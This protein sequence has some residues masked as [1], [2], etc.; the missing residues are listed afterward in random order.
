MNALRIFLQLLRRFEFSVTRPE[1][2]AQIDNAVRI[3]GPPPKFPAF[4]VASLVP[5][6]TSSR[7]SGSWKTSGFGSQAGLRDEL[8]QVHFV[9][10]CVGSLLI[11]PKRLVSVQIVY[12]I[13]IIP[14]QRDCIAWG[15]YLQCFLVGTRLDL[16]SRHTSFIGI[17]QLLCLIIHNSRPQFKSVHDADL[18]YSQQSSQKD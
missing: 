6:L 2:P 1:K 7:V 17:E 4:G 9:Q 16:I 18:S 12:S 13:I 15:L 5:S 3:H 14:G 8:R 10:I 11:P